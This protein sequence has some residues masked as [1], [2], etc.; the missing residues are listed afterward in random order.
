MDTETRDTSRESRVCSRKQI[1]EDGLV[2]AKSQE[3][4]EVKLGS[5]MLD[6]IEQCQHAMLFP[7]EKKPK[8][9]NPKI[10]RTKE[11]SVN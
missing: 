9:L 3:W 6:T 10:L 5:Y 8:I 2:P 7:S 1:T 4:K 11:S